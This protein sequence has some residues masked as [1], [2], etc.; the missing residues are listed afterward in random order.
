MSPNQVHA[1]SLSNRRQA[2]KFWNG[3]DL[4]D[5]NC[6]SHVSTYNWIHMC[7]PFAKKKGKEEIKRANLLLRDSGWKGT[8]PVQHMNIPGKL[9]SIR[10]SA[11]KI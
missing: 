2:H 10:C 6:Y 1:I 11:I 3:Q 4:E 5:Y 8:T 7:I 9:A